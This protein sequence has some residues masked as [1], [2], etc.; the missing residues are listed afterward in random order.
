MRLKDMSGTLGNM[1][2]RKPTQPG[3]NKT[4]KNLLILVTK[5]L[6]INSM[7]V[8]GCSGCYQNSFLPLV[9]FVSLQ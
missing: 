2:Y 7:V 4:E 6:Q 1:S 5:R 9:L 3:L 8:S